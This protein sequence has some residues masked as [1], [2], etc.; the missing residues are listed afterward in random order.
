MSEPD[1]IS[2][3]PPARVS[4]NYAALR[5]VG[6]EKIRTWASESWTDHN[7]HDPGITILEACTYAMTELGLRLEQDVGDLLRSGESIRTA[8]LAPAHRVL[9]VGPV[10]PADLR[11]ILLDHPLVRD[12]QLFLPA[13]GEVLFYGPPLT[14][15]PGPSRIRPG[16]LYEV[17]VELADPELTQDLNSNTY[18]FP[19]PSGGT[20][21][22][23][24]LALPFWEEPEAAPFRQ[25]AVVSAAAMIL[26]GGQAWRALPEPQSFFGKIDITYLTAAGTDHVVTWAVLRITTALPQPG[27]VL[28][29]I[30]AAART[31]VEST[32][33]GP[34]AAPV[35][36]FAAR[37]RRAAVAVNQLQS[38]LAAWRNLGEQAV[39]IGVARVQ[40][41]AVRARIE[42]TG[43][44]DVE[45]LLANIFVAL[46][47]IL[48]P[49]VQFESLSTRVRMHSDPDI[50]YQGP[51]LRHGFLAKSAAAAPHP[52][53]LFVSDVLRVIMRQRSAAGT[54]L[55]TQENPAG[56]DIVAV[57]DLALTNFISN[58]PITSDAQNCLKLVE[59][60]RYRPR[61]SVAKSR[62]VLMRND[63]E[64]SY[65]IGRV[66]RLVKKAVAKLAQ[67]SR[68]DDT[69]PVWP[70]KRGD[71]LPI[72]EYTPL[73]EELPA[74]YGVGHA[75]LPDSAGTSRLAGVRQLQGYLF[76]FEQI[77]ADVTTQLVNINL[78]FSGDASEDTTYFTR[79]PFDLPGAPSLMRRFTPGDNWAAF[80]QNPNNPV[81]RALHDAAERGTEVLDRRNRML[82]H[83]LARQGED[84][85]AFG[86]ELH[87]WA[88]LELAAVNL[89]AGE[90]A[91]SIAARRDAAN[92]RL[93]Q[94]KAALLHDAPELNAFRLL[95]HSN[96]LFG[97][98]DLLRITP[99]GAQ[100]NWHLVP[101]NV[102]RLRSVVPSDTKATAHV[103]GENALAFAAR[104]ELY[105]IVDI[106][107]GLRR[108][109]VKDGLTAAAHVVA[110]SSQTFAGD[111]AA[112]AAV[113]E[114]AGIFARLRIQSSP[115]PFERRIAYLTG[116]RGSL[117]RGL[118]TATS[119]NFQIVDDPPGGGLFGKRWTLFE[120]PGNAGQ[121]L[122]KSP[123]RF[124]APTDAAAVQLAE[125]SI[126]KVLRYGVDEWNYAILPTAPLTYQLNDPSG[127]VLARRDAALASTGDVL[128]AITATAD[129]LYR[130]YGVEGFYLIEHLLLRPR[131]APTPLQ[132]AGDP[133]LSLPLGTARER[134][135]YSQRVSLVFPSGNARDFAQPRA[136][137]PT[138]PVTP[139]RFRDP[140]FR[141]SAERVIRQACP[142]HLM[143]TVYWVDRASPASP[144]SPAS[145]DTFEQRY[146]TWL[147]TILIPGALAA[148]VDAARAAMV[149]TLN[150]IANDTL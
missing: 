103:D 43:G 3:E 130:S 8:D 132:P 5:E 4:M 137:A 106:G 120:L 65:D 123:Q 64:V 125:D 100:F 78:F 82:D 94:L 54:D 1:T 17:L 107:G 127:A 79:P 47:T 12:A 71:R 13:D 102:E 95:A 34:P 81:A 112:A 46:E 55:V 140:E 98:I 59:I 96:P 29:G 25:G 51:L 87:R 113:T 134:D 138:T 52:S 97:N 148:T 126:R 41:I 93:I 146:L 68:T 75:V 7:L 90:Q 61:L 141:N 117:R 136:T 133:F 40:E 45:Q 6:M 36:R 48:S 15:T 104:R 124:D 10:T 122:L 77:L 57:T 39:R 67:A 128:S 84:M 110:E 143:P 21:Y 91:A 114:I 139:D 74:I 109:H 27:L 83:L 118:P 23:V 80:I 11:S 119:V 73:Q 38:Y 2:S 58:R 31:E 18:S 44:I 63:S 37:V 99:A 88:Q 28:P 69:S 20:I 9:P 85:V 108:L 92:A 144:I 150:A 19:V 49:R 26:D 135:P 72:D 56:R 66:E 70:V 101:E 149:E 60:E 16:G 111:P 105:V 53:V 131:R 115:S 32:A 22:D 24:D 35:I 33:L 86:Q 121:E 116:I 129:L 89:P 147:D 30:L 76:L 50:I 42:V 142:A 62:L 145:F 14:Y